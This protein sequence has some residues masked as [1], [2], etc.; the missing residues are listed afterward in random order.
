MTKELKRI[1]II[2]DVAGLT[3]LKKQHQLDSINA[4][5]L[6]EEF[7]TLD[8]HEIIELQVIAIDGNKKQCEIVYR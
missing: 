1:T 4:E 6:P 7:R 5:Y 3:E 8:E 2:T